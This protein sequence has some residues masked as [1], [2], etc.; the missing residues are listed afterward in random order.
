MPYI[1]VNISIKLSDHEKDVLKTK[2]GELISIIPGKTE[3]GL[4]IGINDGYTMYFS[5]QKKEKVAYLN[6]KLYKQAEYEYKNE[7]SKKI[8]EFF[9]KE[10]DITG[11]NLYMNF[12]EYSSWATR[13]SLN[14]Q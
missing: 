1:D 5:G 13:G 8:F 9:E 3:S 12:D 6:I 4:M 14:N 7:L 10:Y 2:L 11:Y